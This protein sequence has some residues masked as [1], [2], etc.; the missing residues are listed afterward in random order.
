M[1][2]IG[3]LAMGW[4]LM[5]AGA[6]LLLDSGLPVALRSRAGQAVEAL[7]GFGLAAAGWMT[8]RAVV[9]TPDKLE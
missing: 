5:L 1:K 6:L 3:R 7:A 4:G 9:K 8:R 2:A